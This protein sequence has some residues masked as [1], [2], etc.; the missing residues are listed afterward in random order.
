MD[1]QEFQK[2]FD[3]I[4]KI[5]MKKDFRGDISIERSGSS[6]NVFL[7]G[8]LFTRVHSDNSN[9]LRFL[10]KITE[11]GKNSVRFAKNASVKLQVQQE[12]K[13]PVFNIYIDDVLMEKTTLTFLPRGTFKKLF[14]EDVVM[15]YRKQKTEEEHLLRE[16][17][18]EQKIEDKEQEVRPDDDDL[19]GFQKRIEQ[20]K[21]RPGIPK[22][23]A[24]YL[25]Q[26]EEM[27]RGRGQSALA[28]LKDVEAMSRCAVRVS[29]KICRSLRGD[30][31]RAM[32]RFRYD[33]N[34]QSC[35]IC[36]KTPVRNKKMYFVIS[37]FV[38]GSVAYRP[39][40]KGSAKEYDLLPWFNGAIYPSAGKFFIQQMVKDIDDDVHAFDRM[41]LVS[42]EI[43]KF[44][45][46]KTAEEYIP[47]IESLSRRQ[48]AKM[49]GS[50][51]YESMEHF[52]AIFIEWLEDKK[53][54]RYST[55]LDAYADFHK[56][57]SAMQLV[58]KWWITPREFKDTNF[59]EQMKA[60]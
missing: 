30:F 45:E 34:N 18:K 7:D 14:S 37:V 43:V 23:D 27:R 52:R 57:A 24:W 36:L 55:W 8:E 58:P 54:K 25:K 35:L 28:A 19:T 20:E 5:S 6:F 1:Q 26:I 60:A 49:I 11:E 47:V 2:K 3:N 15:K 16:A 50:L 29:E 41:T 39:Y 48:I 32:G 59:Y 44:P 9:A 33:K 17:L 4:E 40:A 53:S 21:K 12:E 22:D 10:N 42:S 13:S 31:S 46:N 38:D 56:E 51:D